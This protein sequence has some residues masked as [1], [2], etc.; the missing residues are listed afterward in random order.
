MLENVPCFKMP[1][2]T[3]VINTWVWLSVHSRFGFHKMVVVAQTSWQDLFVKQHKHWLDIRWHS[4]GVL[5]QFEKSQTALGSFQLNSDR[6]RMYDYTKTCF[7][8]SQ[9]RVIYRYN[10]QIKATSNHNNKCNNDALQYIR[11]K[12]EWDPMTFLIS[13]CGTI[14]KMLL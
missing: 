11:Q 7:T 1:S 4:A 5:V 10:N 3:A 6:K 2:V 12:Q 9:D 14:K 13:L 8:S